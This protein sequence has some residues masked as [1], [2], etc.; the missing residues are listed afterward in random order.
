MHRKSNNTT[1]RMDTPNLYAKYSV[2]VNPGPDLNQIQGQV[3]T[4]NNTGNNFT[5]PITCS[6][7]SLGINLLFRRHDGEW[8]GLEVHKNQIDNFLNVYEINNPKT[9]GEI[10]RND[11]KKKVQRGECPQLND[12]SVQNQVNNFHL[13]NFHSQLKINHPNSFEITPPENKIHEKSLLNAQK[14]LNIMESLKFSL[15][16]NFN[17]EFNKIFSK[18]KSKVI[19]IK[20]E[21]SEEPFSRFEVSV[22]LKNPPFEENMIFISGSE[23]V[24]VIS[25]I[26]RI[27][28]ENIENIENIDSQINSPQIQ[29][30]LNS[31][32]NIDFNQINSIEL[33]SNFLSQQ[34][35][36]LIYSNIPNSEQQVV[37]LNVEN[38]ENFII[39]SENEN[40]RSIN[41]L[42]P[43]MTEDLCSDPNEFQEFH[44]HNKKRKRNSSEENKRPEMELYSSII[45][46]E[47]HDP[48][49]NK[50]LKSLFD[51][52]KTEFW[53]TKFYKVCIECG[54]S[55]YFSH[56]NACCNNFMCNS[57][58]KNNY[59]LL[60]ELMG[61]EILLPD[62]S[63]HDCFFC[64]QNFYFC[65]FCLLI[66]LKENLIRCESSLCFGLFHED[67]YKA[68]IIIGRSKGLGNLPYSLKHEFYREFSSVFLSFYNSISRLQK[69]EENEKVLKKINLVKINCNSNNMKSNS[70]SSSNMNFTF[71][72]RLYKV[73]AIS[74]LKIFNQ[75]FPKVVVREFEGLFK[76]YFVNQVE[77]NSDEKENFYMSIQTLLEGKKFCQIHTCFNCF[78]YIDEMSFN[79]EESD[80]SSVCCL[81]T[82]IICYSEQNKNVEFNLDK[83]NS[84]DKDTNHN[85]KHDHISNS[86]LNQAHNSLQHLKFYREFYNLMKKSVQDFILVIEKSKVKYNSILALERKMKL[87]ELNQ[88]N[89]K[90]EYIISQV[91]PNPVMPENN[92]NLNNFSE[93]NLFNQKAPN[94]QNLPVYEKLN[95]EEQNILKKYFKEY[96]V[97]SLITSIKIPTSLLKNKLG[98]NSDRPKCQCMKEAVEK[99]EKSRGNKKII[100]NFAPYNSNQNF[101]K[102]LESENIFICW[103]T[104]CPN[105]ADKVECNKS[106]CYASENS[107]SNRF[108]I[109]KNFLE[110]L[111]I[112]KTI[113]KYEYGLIANTNFQQGELILEVFGEI[114]SEEIYLNEIREDDVLKPYWY[115]KRYPGT[116]LYLYYFEKGNYARY[117]N[118]SCNP[119]AS[120]QLWEGESRIK[121]V[122]ITSKSKNSN[123]KDPL[124][125]RF[126]IF[127]SQEINIDTEITL[128]YNTPLFNHDPYLGSIYKFECKC[129]PECSSIIGENLKKEIIQEIKNHETNF[130][131]IFHLE[132]FKSPKLIF[133]NQLDP[134]DL[135]VLKEGKFFLVRNILATKYKIIYQV[136]SGKNLNSKIYYE[137]LRSLYYFLGQ[138]RCHF[139]KEKLRDKNAIHF[140]QN[141]WK[142][143][144]LNCTSNA[145]FNEEH[146]CLKCKQRN[147]FNIIRVNRKNITIRMNNQSR[148]LERSNSEILLLSEEKIINEKIYRLSVYKLNYTVNRVKLYSIF[149]EYEIEANVYN[150]VLRLRKKFEF[151]KEKF[152]RASSD[153]EVRYLVKA[154]NLFSDFLSDI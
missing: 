108:K 118:H 11:L 99:Y 53:N 22:Q 18:I 145:K 48:E 38:F 57:C 122:N 94:D 112:V 16:S 104:N 69:E 28:T 121:Y 63:D 41:L 128:D 93:I 87:G 151:L 115:T 105:R 29:I 139:C 100:N 120:L 24:Q 148:V 111:A 13:K 54:K 64:S 3:N 31:E 72:L 45:K 19:E 23:Q 60:V 55:G 1:M 9:L 88:I 83:K 133:N 70:L 15:Q 110:E 49:G 37:S 58:I 21:G 76:S 149:Y 144:H 39:S 113:S 125:K 25:P 14:T 68:S 35:S 135:F 59:S 127:A 40:V 119:N 42:S 131:E 150:R 65:S 78:C 26:E 33:N 117:I 75:V 134:Y 17:D 126:L 73:N 6:L 140:C 77:C 138:P 89:E 92:C 10:L 32:N 143:F 52:E 102:F 4:F 81:N 8:L 147:G 79:H 90:N 123:I 43:A 124:N 86:K 46:L 91:T 27:N 51:F 101:K 141:C 61:R 12:F 47:H 44:T 137:I 96:L 129:H 142:S 130:I 56:Y 50:V 106:I 136:L 146:M 2:T 114:I 116:N 132:K 20:Q 67:C 103:N 109:P 62:K 80:F 98:S 71:M 7:E 34:Y 152:L 5:S 95:S 97:S 154:K 36:Q 107:C 74:F 82:H 30:Q 85:H 66:D 153:D 84:N